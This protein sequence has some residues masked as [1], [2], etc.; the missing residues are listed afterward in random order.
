MAFVRITF[1]AM[2]TPDPLERAIPVV[3]QGVRRRAVVAAQVRIDGRGAV[4]E[5]ES[6]LIGELGETRLRTRFT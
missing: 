4:L 3:F 5:D 6:V 1:P 2:T